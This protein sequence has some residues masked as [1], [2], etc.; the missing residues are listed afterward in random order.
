[1][2][3]A[4]GDNSI[5]WE[6]DIVFLRKQKQGIKNVLDA[7]DQMSDYLGQGIATICYVIKPT[8][9]CFRWR[10]YGSRSFLKNR[11][12]RAFLYKYLLPTIAA[13]KNKI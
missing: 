2:A 4:H 1:M 8:N 5:E 11:I 7:I 13:R 6:M 10:D 12:E 3:K 9:C